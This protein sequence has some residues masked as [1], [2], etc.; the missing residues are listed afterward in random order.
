VLSEELITQKTISSE[1][2]GKCRSSNKAE[3]VDRIRNVIYTTSI[4]DVE[5]GFT[6]GVCVARCVAF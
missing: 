6:F 5:T 1:E 4:I 3:P 2:K